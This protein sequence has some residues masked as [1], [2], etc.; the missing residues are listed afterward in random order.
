MRADM[1]NWYEIKVRGIIGSEVHDTKENTILGAALR[2][3]R[4][5]ES[6]QRHRCD[7]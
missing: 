7:L 2:W 1:E 4:E 5:F 3:K 6:D